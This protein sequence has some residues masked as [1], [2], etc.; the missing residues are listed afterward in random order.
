MG[1]SRTFWIVDIS[2]ISFF[3]EANPSITLR[4]TVELIAN[5][6]GLFVLPYDLKL[7]IDPGD[8]SPFS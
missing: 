4:D 7:K 8:G 5:V 2:G 3:C 1:S 6:S